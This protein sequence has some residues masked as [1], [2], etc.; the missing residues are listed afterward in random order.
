MMSIELVLASNNDHKHAEFRRLFPD[1]TVLSPRDVGVTFDFEETGN[2]FFDNAR[3]KALALFRRAG[4]AVIADDSGLCVQA[5]GGAP[6]IMSNR[7]GAAADGTVLETGKR[8]AFLL[9]KL[10]G[11]ADRRAFFVCC[12]VLVQDEERFTSVQETVHGVITEEPRGRNGFGYD[13]LFLLPSLGMTMAEL[14][15]AQ[16]DELSHRGRAARRLGA[17][18]SLD[19]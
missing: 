4:R 19:S 3:G 17:C 16:K 2:T 13:P 6:G 18:L 9:E 14:P 5:L 15:D 12:L 7:Y 8:N 11:I 1:V 10:A